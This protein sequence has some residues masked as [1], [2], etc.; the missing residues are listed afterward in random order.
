MV[1]S[2]LAEAASSTLVKIVMVAMRFV[3]DVEADTAKHHCR[4]DLVATFGP[5]IQGFGSSSVFGVIIMKVIDLCEL[6][7]SL[8]DTK[9][10]FGMPHYDSLDWTVLNST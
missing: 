2:I 8:C 1:L 7:F 3:C 4:H 6:G 5:H 9:G 10:V